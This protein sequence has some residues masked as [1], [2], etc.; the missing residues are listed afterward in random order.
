MKKELRHP[1]AECDSNMSISTDSDLR[2]SV[3]HLREVLM[4]MAN[5]RG[6]LREMPVDEIINRVK[7][8]L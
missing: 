2:I 5:L 1:E 3:E 6:I 8:E 4:D 7:K